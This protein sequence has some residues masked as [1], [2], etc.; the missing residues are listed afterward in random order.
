MK[1]VLFLLF[2]SFL[3]LLSGC[4]DDEYDLS[5]FTD[6]ELYQTSWEGELISKDEVTHKVSLFFYNKNLCLVRMIRV[7]DQ[8]L[9]EHS[10]TYYV[11]GHAIEIH[12]GPYR[13]GRWVI[14]K[15]SSESMTLEKGA[16]GLGADVAKF[17]RKG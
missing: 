8:A 3:P 17:R 7:Y 12:E 10:L 6:K 11:Q 13:L 2:L 16:G 14:V 9:A 15:F 5:N 1:K 4:K